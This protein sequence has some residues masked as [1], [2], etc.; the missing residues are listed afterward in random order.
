M[1]QDYADVIDAQTWAFIRRT[2]SFYPPDTAQ[3]T[4][5]EQRSIYNTMCAAFHQGYPA[6]MTAKDVTV[7]GVPVRHYTPKQVLG[8]AQVLYFH[9]GG[10]V[11]GG[12]ESHDDVCAELSDRTGFALT[13]VDYRLWPEHVHPAAFEDCLAVTRTV[14]T[15]GPQPVI[16]VGDSAGGTL[17]AAVALALR[18]HPQLAGVVLIYPGLGG[19]VNRGSYLTQAHA[20]MLSRDD[21]LF[22]KDIR[23]AADHD[24][25]AS[26]LA[27]ADLTGLPPVV[28]FAAECDPLADDAGEFCARITAQGGVARAVL[29]RGLVHGYLRARTEVYRARNSFTRIVD[30][31]AACAT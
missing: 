4:L 3:R 14:L 7:A 24:I 11:V 31:I 21:V 5:A 23:Q 9:G 12:L 27:A 22:Y 13:S 8:P 2:E 25:T 19:D 1:Q 6:E 16:L 26:P 10:F 20:P 29:E 28:A 18:G 15:Q 17:A 30:A